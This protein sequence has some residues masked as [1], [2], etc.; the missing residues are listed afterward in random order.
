M[1]H[2]NHF[3]GAEGLL[4]MAFNESKPPCVSSDS[5]MEKSSCDGIISLRTARRASNASWRESK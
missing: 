4:S 3:F 5:G 2:V 1:G